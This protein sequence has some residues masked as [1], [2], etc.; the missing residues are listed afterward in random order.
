MIENNGWSVVII[1]FYYYYYYHCDVVKLT[2]ATNLINDCVK[3]VRLLIQRK[4]WSVVI[5]EL[6]FLRWSVVIIK[7]LIVAS[8]NA[9]VDDTQ[10]WILMNECTIISRLLMIM[11]MIVL[12]TNFYV[13]DMYYANYILL[14]KLIY[15][16]LISKV[17][18]NSTLLDL[19]GHKP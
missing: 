16:W 9:R 6:Q 11:I 10:Y 2:Y 1:E 3:N 15:Y 17:V 19:H 18:F 7:S 5:I 14:R 13:H 12:D 8:H 4:G